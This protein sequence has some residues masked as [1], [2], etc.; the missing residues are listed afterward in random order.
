MLRF[1][2]KSIFLRVRISMKHS[3]NTALQRSAMSIENG[4]PHS[5]TPAECY[6]SE[7]TYRSDGAEMSVHIVAINILLRWSKESFHFVCRVL[8]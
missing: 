4:M 1:N 3:E 8:I 5:R 2:G 6:V 7:I